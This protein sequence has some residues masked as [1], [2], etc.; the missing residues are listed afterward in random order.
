LICLLDQSAFRYDF[1][2][3]A[4]RHRDFVTPVNF[5]VVIGFVLA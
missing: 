4:Y 2:V 3:I 1:A 5:V